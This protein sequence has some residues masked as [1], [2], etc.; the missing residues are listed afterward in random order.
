[1]VSTTKIFWRSLMITLI[2]FSAGLLLG[3]YLDN[4]RSNEVYDELRNYEL[5]TESY[6]VEQAFWDAFDIN[7]CS[8]AEKRLNSISTELVELG[9]YLNSYE[10]KSIFKDKEFEYLAQRYFLLEIKGYI[11]I[12]ELKEECNLQNDVILYF[13]NPDD[14]SSEL[15]GYVLDH[16]VKQSNGTLDVFSINKD[17]DD[18]AIKSLVIYYNVTT[19]PTLIINGKVK[20]GYTNYS[21]IQKIIDENSS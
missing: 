19:S 10:T 20:E 14:D 21:G 17:F 15:Q 9:Y 5:N 1:M 6:L 7:D 13:Y 18:P 8:M 11:L 4:I 2:I 12:T 16:L 3:L